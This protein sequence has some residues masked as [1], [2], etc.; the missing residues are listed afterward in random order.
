MGWGQIGIG[1]VE[2]FERSEGLRDNT[3]KGSGSHYLLGDVLANETDTYFGW[4][5][6]EDSLCPDGCGRLEGM[7]TKVADGQS[8]VLHDEV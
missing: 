4:Q 6:N 1:S 2:V 8:V 3:G 5:F 7:C